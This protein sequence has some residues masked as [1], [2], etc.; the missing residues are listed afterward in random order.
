VLRHVPAGL[1]KRALFK[2]AAARAE[3]LLPRAEQSVGVVHRTISPASVVLLAGD[4]PALVDFRYAGASPLS[5]YHLSYRSLAQT[6]GG[7]YRL[8]P[9]RCPSYVRVTRASLVS[10]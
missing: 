7:L 4:A 6:P 5:P 2:R 10:D 8:V 1:V 3:R 9:S